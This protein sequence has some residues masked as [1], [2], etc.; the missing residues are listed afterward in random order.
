MQ[1]AK[2]LKLAQL[3]P[4]K[5]R[6]L[7]VDFLAVDFP[8]LANGKENNFPMTLPGEHLINFLAPRNA[9]KRQLVPKLKK[10]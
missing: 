4:F 6:Q 10:K 2:T 9:H 8:L 5:F 1:L 3:A 7:S